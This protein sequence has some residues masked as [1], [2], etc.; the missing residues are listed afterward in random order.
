MK[1]NI[2]FGEDYEEESKE[3][4]QSEQQ[5]NN[6]IYN[7][8]ETEEERIH[9]ED[10]EEHAESKED[11]KTEQFEEEGNRKD[12]EEYQDQDYENQIIGSEDVENSRHNDVENSGHHDF[13][14][15]QFDDLSELEDM[16][17]D[18]LDNIGPEIEEVDKPPSS[19]KKE[20]FEDEGDYS[21]DDDEFGEISVSYDDK[22]IPTFEV[23]PKK[24]VNIKPPSSLKDCKIEFVLRYVF[25]FYFLGLAYIYK[26]DEKPEF[27][28]KFMEKSKKQIDLLILRLEKTAVQI[29]PDT[30]KKIVENSELIGTLLIVASLH[31]NFHALAMEYKKKETT[32]TTAKKEKTNGD[33]QEIKNNANP[34]QDFKDVNTNSTIK[35]VLPNLSPY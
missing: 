31:Y 10:H 16:A 3:Q 30:Y 2:V 18:E 28:E 35:S 15:S 24:K 8:E 7:D 27:V 13:M 22:N 5:E 25:Y 29:A 20:S 23:I 14:T 26:L 4:E 9:Q 33:Q 1:T 19:D 6:R 34:I 17:L 11:N 21:E 12:E 32:P